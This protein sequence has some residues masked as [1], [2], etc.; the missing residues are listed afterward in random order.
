MKRDMDLIREILLE[1]EKSS[2]DG[3]RIQINGRGADEL[4]Y[5]A[6]QAR[7]AGLIDAKFLPNSTDFYVLRLTYEG[8]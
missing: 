8:Q 1:V 5:N 2:L 3:C 6:M 4:Y 7:D